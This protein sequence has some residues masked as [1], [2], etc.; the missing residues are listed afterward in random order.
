MGQVKGK[1]KDVKSDQASADTSSPDKAGSE[2]NVQNTREDRRVRRS[3]IHFGV[4]IS[5]FCG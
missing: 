4:S 1:K 2:K 5:R 3:R